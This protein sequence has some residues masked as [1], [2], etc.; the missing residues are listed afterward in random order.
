MDEKSKELDEIPKELAKFT[1]KELI[2]LKET[3]EAGLKV[4]SPVLASQFY[5]LFL[6]GYNCAAIAKNNPPFK[7]GDV[8]YLREKHKWDESK[9]LYATN[10]HIQ[11]RDKLIKQKL[12][13]VEF[14]T[15]AIAVAHKS[16]NA[17][18]LKYL[19]T[20][21]EE[22]MPSE[23]WVTGPA[24]YKS[25]LETL[26][27]ITGEDRITTQN[28]KNETTVVV[29]SEQKQVMDETKKKTML[30]KLSGEE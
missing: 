18:M 14:L 15:N 28:I 10:L 30:R 11:I 12:E 4:I 25:I 26:Q 3:K 20:G 24:S 29:K 5:E 19:Q 17:K 2:T 7:E 27:K 6:E 13:S 23:V 8:L 22:D 9:E 16:L 21:Q 1:E